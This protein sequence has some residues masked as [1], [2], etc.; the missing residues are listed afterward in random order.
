MQHVCHLSILQTYFCCGN[1][2]IFALPWRGFL[3][4]RSRASSW[5]HIRITLVTTARVLIFLLLF[6]LF[7]IVDH[8]L[9]LHL[10]II[11]QVVTIFDRRFL[12]VF[13][14]GG[15]GVALTFLLHTTDLPPG[16]A[17]LAAPSEPS[18]RSVCQIDGFVA[19][20]LQLV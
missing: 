14:I 17:H 3:L 8:S 16:P 15:S 13:L 9:R 10:I 6:S 2:L 12:H 20:T 18:V 5:H 19:H 7:S 1:R 11:V 4:L